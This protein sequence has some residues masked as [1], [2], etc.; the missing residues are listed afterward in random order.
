M[1]FLVAVGYPTASLSE[2]WR[3]AYRRSAKRAPGF[4][5]RDRREPARCTDPPGD[6]GRGLGGTVSRYSGVYSHSRHQ[7]GRAGRQHTVRDRDPCRRSRPTADQG[8]HL[9][10]RAGL[11][12]AW[13]PVGPA[14]PF[15]VQGPPF[16]Y[17]LSLVRPLPRAVF[18]VILKKRDIEP[19]GDSGRLS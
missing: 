5:I 2:L 1:V 6:R 15:P 9:R 4:H 17:W 7:T 3:L 12:A 11:I 14:T 16:P 18:F 8:L 19:D 13:W 10:L